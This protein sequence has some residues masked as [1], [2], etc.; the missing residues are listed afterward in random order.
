MHGKQIRMSFGVWITLVIAMFAGTHSQAQSVNQAAIASRNGDLWEF[1][2]YN[3]TATQL[4]TW[5]FNGGPILSPDGTK[6]AY[7]STATE[8]IDRIN[9]GGNAQFAGSPPANIWILD[10]ATDNYTRIADQSGAGEVGYIRSI[11][12]WSP[13]SKKLIWSQLDPNYQGLDQA[14]L[15]VYDLN[16]RLTATFVSNYNLG[17]QDGGIWMPPVKWGDGGISRILFTYQEGSRD[18][19]LFMEIYNP[20]NGNLTTYNLG[21]NPGTGN[22]VHDHIW[23]NHEGR[24][25]IALRSRNV[26]E[27]FDPTNGSRSVLTA[28][29]RLKSSFITPGMELIPVPV[30]DERSEWVL[31]WQAQVNNAVY[32]IGYT[33]YGL[34]NG[35][36]PAISFDSAT[37]AWHN[38]EGVS[39]WSV[40]TGQSGRST[41]P[42]AQAGENYY[43]IPQPHT[44]VWAPTTWVTSSTVVQ[45][46]PTPTY[47]PTT[48]VCNLAPRLAVGQNAVVVPGPSNRVRVGATVN[49]AVIDQI[50]QGEI[51][52]VERGPVCADGYN[53][54]FVRNGRIAGWTAEGGDGQY[55]L[56]VDTGSSY[57]YNSP[58]ARL[59][60]NFQGIVLPGE[61][62]NLRDNIGTNGT[63]VVTVMPAGETFVVK[64]TSQCDAEGR[65]WFPIQYK[66]FTGW[67]AEGEGTEYWVAPVAS[68]G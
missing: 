16:T 26:W 11:P 36:T 20:I 12:A 33:S 8:V 39:T 9:A 29:P 58:P 56:T 65:R 30:Q 40:N 23:V 2:I 49:S 61:P 38:G 45:P 6:I 7:L 31:Q 10:L 24:S 51:V 22:Y 68:T 67:T 54:F 18:P 4:T 3:N 32:N 66:Q 1:D 17:F 52:Y 43:L 44:V 48:H 47:P 63:R 34:D 25:M 37:V 62:N 59:I 14:T 41:T 5:N 50:S 60:P 21:F 13:D 64:G 19:F 57:C 35:F 27:L 42:Q 55:W 15:Q 53:W 46:Q 28:P